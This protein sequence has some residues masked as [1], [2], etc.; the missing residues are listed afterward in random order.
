MIFTINGLQFSYRSKSVIHDTSF[1][2]R[3][4]EILAILG[5]NGAG[6]TTLLK[7]LNR[8]LHPQGG[9]VELDGRD[10]KG[11]RP[12]EIARRIGWVP[13]RGELSRM[14]VYDVI[15]LGRK[16]HFRWEPAV[17]D[18]RHV[19]EAIRFM[20]I[21]DIALRYVDEL[22]GGEFQLVQIVRALAQDPRI[23]LFDEPTSSLDILNQHTLMKKLQSVIHDSTRA[24]VMVMHDINLALR[25]SDKFLFLS[26]GHVSAIGDHSII[27]PELIR[28]VYGID[29]RVIKDGHD[30]LVV[31]L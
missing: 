25:Y 15:L 26:D 13:Q 7:C 31:P 5:R 20:G 30:T 11:M 8:V 2:V 3:E 12:V 9:R 14:K 18:F 23:I 10:L 16:P 6:K 21:E 24:A 17:G 1:E 4:G 27:T 19:E 22:S 28:E 29:V